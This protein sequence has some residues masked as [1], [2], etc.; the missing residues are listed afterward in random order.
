YTHLA[1]AM[2]IG[3][4]APLALK[5]LQKTLGKSSDSKCLHSPLNASKQDRYAFEVTLK[6][7]LGR[8]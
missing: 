1:S 5:Q 2:A 8:E 7:K 6:Y 3:R 4:V